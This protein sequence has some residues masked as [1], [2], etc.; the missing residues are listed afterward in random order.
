MSRRAQSALVAVCFVAGVVLMT[1][2]DAAVTRAVGV[3]CLLGFVAGGLFLI[4]DPVLLSGGAAD[5]DR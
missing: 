3:A 4:A 1:F 2:F 5:R